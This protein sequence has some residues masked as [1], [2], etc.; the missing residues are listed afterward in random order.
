MEK[1]ENAACRWR[2]T[3]A[4]R[5]IPRNAIIAVNAPMAAAANVPTAR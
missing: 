1:C 4:A 2:M 3:R 5:V